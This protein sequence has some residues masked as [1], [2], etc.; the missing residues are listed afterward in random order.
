MCGEH[1][2]SSGKAGLISSDGGR[3]AASSD[4]EGLAELRD[5]MS[6]ALFGI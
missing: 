2:G 4:K 1:Y 6:L 3:K 5:L